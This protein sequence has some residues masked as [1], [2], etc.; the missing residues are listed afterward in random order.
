[1]K[2]EVVYWNDFVSEKEFEAV[3]YRQYLAAVAFVHRLE[4]RLKECKQAQKKLAGLT[5]QV[6]RKLEHSTTNIE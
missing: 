1:M 3:K 5:N 4:T 2:M 6:V